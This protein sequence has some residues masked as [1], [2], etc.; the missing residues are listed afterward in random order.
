MAEQYLSLTAYIEP[1]E[2]MNESSREGW[3]K[4]GDSALVH[5][6]ADTFY[7]FVISHEEL[8]LD[9][10]RDIL[11]ENGIMTDR[12]DEADVSGKSGKCVLAMMYAAVRAERFCDGFLLDNCKNGTIVRWLKR[13]RE[14]DEEGE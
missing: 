14:L 3:P 9:Y 10:Y 7:R 12:L 6:L 2:R 5:S 8:R 11:A 4:D 13:L 1:I